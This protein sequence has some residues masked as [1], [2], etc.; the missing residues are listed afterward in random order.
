VGTDTDGRRICSECGYK[1]GGPSRLEQ[2]IKEQKEQI[3][4]WIEDPTKYIETDEF[5]KRGLRDLEEITDDFRLIEGTSLRY[6]L[7]SQKSP[8]VYPDSNQAPD[9][10]Q[11]ILDRG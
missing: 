2:K 5:I 7:S 4:S 8:F 11:I 3:D 10:D 6:M 9:P 1:V